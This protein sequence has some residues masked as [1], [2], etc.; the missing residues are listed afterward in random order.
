MKILNEK[1]GKEIVALTVKGLYQDA[2]GFQQ[3]VWVTKKQLERLLEAQFHE[4]EREYIFRIGDR[5][6]R[7]CDMLSFKIV[8][9]KEAV[10]WPSFRRYI[11]DELKAEEKPKL[12]KPSEAK[13]RLV[14]MKKELLHGK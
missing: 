8:E 11:L 10:W 13:Q 6:I 4:K 9:L 12:E 1:H 14:S 3:Y 5:G 7:P 2:N